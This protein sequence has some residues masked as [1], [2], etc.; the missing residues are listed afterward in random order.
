MKKPE[1]NIFVSHHH[2]EFSTKDDLSQV[3]LKDF[4]LLWK[5]TFELRPNIHISEHLN[6]EQ[7]E[8]LIQKAD[9]YII[10]LTPA[11]KK[12]EQCI[13]ELHNILATSS[14]GMRNVF[15]IRKTEM[16]DHEEPIE[17]QNLIGYDFFGL[18]YE[19]QVFFDYTQG[20][21]AYWERLDDLVE[22]IGSFLQPNLHQQK[23]GKLYLALTTPDRSA[24][25][26]EL[27]RDFKNH[28]YEVLPKLKP[29]RKQKALEKFVTKHLE[30]CDF[31]VHILGELY[32]ETVEN[33]Q[34]SLVSFQLEMV[35][36]YN[37]K[38]PFKHFVLLPNK[39]SITVRKQSKL[40]ESLMLQES[41]QVNAEIVQADIESFKD[42]VYQ[43]IADLAKKNNA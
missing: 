43:N 32:G 18:D 37:E 24:D 12:D 33:S 22:D 15:K 31:S 3:I 40:I 19:L 41:A 30:E 10:I 11:Y 13:Q 26:R 14:D 42:I 25:F 36:K 4:H 16:L 27:A 35:R 28:G 38:V 2:G 1:I 17:I 9:A 29:P 7:R 8:P 20:H 21:D 34:E 6:F 5:H 23:K 39:N